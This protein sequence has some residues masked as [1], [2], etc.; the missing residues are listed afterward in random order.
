MKLFKRIGLA[1]GA[2]YWIALDLCFAVLAALLSLLLVTLYA[3]LSALYSGATLT[4]VSSVL[5]AL[6]LFYPVVVARE[7]LGVASIGAAGAVV[8]LGARSAAAIGGDYACGLA[9]AI[10][11]CLVLL[12]EPRQ[13]PAHGR[14]QPLRWV[15][16]T[17]A[18]VARGAACILAPAWS[19]GVLNVL[20]IAGNLAWMADPAF[21]G[22]R[23]R[24]AL[25]GAALGIAAMSSPLGAGLDAAA[26]SLEAIA[27][28][29]RR[30]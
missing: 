14:Q 12:A 26:F 6:R 23:L 7:A 19:T 27:F 5:L 29:T 22:S 16:L 8:G 9:L 21:E 2:S 3:T 15:L 30:P 1:F 13:S 28:I 18:V 10:Y 24:A 20:V 11:L 17:G 4:S 25:G